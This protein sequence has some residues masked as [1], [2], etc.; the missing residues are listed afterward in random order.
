MIF[1]PTPLT[2]AVLV[3]PERREDVRGHFARLYC[4]REFAERG[5]PSRMVQTNLS[6]TRKAGTLRGMHWQAAPH[7]EDKL[8]GCV[9]GCIWDVIVDVRAGSDTYCRW[10]G[11]ELS[12]T[13]GRM[14]LV[15]KGFAHGFLTLEDE[16]A[17]LY[18]MSQF[19]LPQAARG[20]RYD[21]SAFGIDWPQQ[22]TKIAQKDRE[23]P[24][25][26]RD[27]AAP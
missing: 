20:A 6:F 26:V 3:D 14:L 4:E 21:D 24:D 8:V 10:F 15:P 11:V 19:H 5:L 2:G 25:F 27:H 23:W 18:Q 16:T 1:T 7:Q 12:Q 17:V 9:R 22:V 13:N